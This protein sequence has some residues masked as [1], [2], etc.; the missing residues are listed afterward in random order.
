MD[1]S[2]KRAW[3]WEVLIRLHVLELTLRFGGGAARRL[4]HRAATE[5]GAVVDGREREARLD[6]VS[7]DAFFLLFELVARQRSEQAVLLLRDAR[8]TNLRGL[9]PLAQRVDARGELARVV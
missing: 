7:A 2:A 5:G 6:L 3:I 8:E 9:E 4:L 1:A